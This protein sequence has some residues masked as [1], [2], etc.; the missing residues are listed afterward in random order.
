V[1]LQITQRF[2]HGSPERRGSLFET[3]ATK[4]RAL[5]EAEAKAVTDRLHAAADGPFEALVAAH[6]DRL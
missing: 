1:I 3:A 6:L 4:I 2:L 5:P